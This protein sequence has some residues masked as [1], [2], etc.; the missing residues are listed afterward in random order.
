MG[1]TCARDLGKGFA[2]VAAEVKTFST[3]K[4]WATE[5]ICKQFDHGRTE[6]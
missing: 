5:E 3:H 6:E 2:V 1:S 4:A